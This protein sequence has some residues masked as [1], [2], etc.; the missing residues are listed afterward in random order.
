MAALRR[1]HS[2]GVAPC[3]SSL[4]TSQRGAF[5]ALGAF[6]LSL[7]AAWA[8]S[9]SKR[10]TV[11][12]AQASQAEKA[13]GVPGRKR[14]KRQKHRSRDNHSTSDA[15]H[16]LESSPESVLQLNHVGDESIINQSSFALPGSITAHEN[17]NDVVGRETRRDPDTEL[18]VGDTLETTDIQSDMLLCSE[19]EGEL[20][21]SNGNSD[22]LNYD[23]DST[24]IAEDDTHEG[25]WISVERR[26]R[27]RKI[28]A[29]TATKDIEPVEAVSCHRYDESAPS[30]APDAPQSPQAPPNPE[31][32]LD[33]ID[34]S[35]MAACSEKS[36]A[37]IKKNKKNS[38]KKKEQKITNVVGSEVVEQNPSI[39][40]P[41][42]A[43]PAPYC[44]LPPISTASY[45][46]ESGT[47][48]RDQ[49]SLDGWT[50]VKL[51]KRGKRPATAEARASE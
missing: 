18:V 43:E 39:Q 49:S 9:A 3:T 41:A 48:Q 42:V 29:K 16:G 50:Q 6:G 14:S 15:S 2:H 45:D 5:I 21:Q 19:H 11:K 17:S 35:P 46:F 23:D 25:P 34:Q 26:Q 38:K 33:M 7:G 32:E 24:S 40:H 36:N 20:D 13:A 10:L 47:S 4:V 31:A 12:D 51:R 30:M 8:W 1:L 37:Q 22:L 28:P 44:S 27:R